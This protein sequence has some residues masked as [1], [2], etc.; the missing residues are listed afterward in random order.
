MHHIPAAD[1]TSS[2][3]QAACAIARRWFV[4]IAFLSLPGDFVKGFYDL[5]VAQYD[6]NELK[7]LA[8]TLIL[9]LWPMMMVQAELARFGPRL[10]EL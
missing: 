1:R 9:H 4:F 8:H 7:A 6:G 2:V 3:A 10:T 5:D